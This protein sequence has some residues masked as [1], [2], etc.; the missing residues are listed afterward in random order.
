VGQAEAELI[1]R[2]ALVMR[3]KLLGD[4]HPDVTESLTSLGAL[5]M[6]QHKLAEAE[7]LLLKTHE[8]LQQNEK[9][10]TK[11]KRN[12]LT[13]LVRLYKDWDKA[14]LAAEW[15]QKLEIF[16]KA[17]AERKSADKTQTQEQ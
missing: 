11:Y 5:L 2:D 14:E 8:S 10:E 6:N 3:Q 15:K 17:E 9:V 1:L 16:D 12:T 7:P 4:S 13:L